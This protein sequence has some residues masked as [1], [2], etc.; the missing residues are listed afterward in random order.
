MIAISHRKGLRAARVIAMLL[1]AAGTGFVTAKL[2]GGGSVGLGASRVAPIRGRPVLAG[3][4]GWPDQSLSADQI[5]QRIKELSQASP[6]LW[7]DWEARMR[8]E[9]LIRGASVGAFAVWHQG[10]AAA[11]KNERVGNSNSRGNAPYEVFSDGPVLGMIYSVWCERDGRTAVEAA[12]SLGLKRPFASNILDSWARLE[13]AAAYEWTIA[14]ESARFLS[15]EEKADASKRSIAALAEKDFAGAKRRIEAGDDQMRAEMLPVL[16]DRLSD[17][18]VRREELIALASESPDREAVLSTMIRE[19]SR[20]SPKEAMARIATLDLPEETKASLENTCLAEVI[21]VFR[22][23]ES[24]EGWFER[25][26]QETEISSEVTRMLASWLSFRPETSL[27]WLNDFPAGEQRDRAFAALREEMRYPED[28]DSPEANP[29]ILNCVRSIKDD[30]LRRGLYQDHFKAL[31]R[32]D[33]AAAMEWRE[34]L[35]EADRPDVGSE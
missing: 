8:I 2:R 24:V 28:D 12:Y 17:D 10:I 1:I 23:P 21:V 16:M 33:E 27:K 26:P 18:P 29:R 5:R 11:L 4:N 25:H 32:R 22:F 19:W 3:K 20:S 15:G 34:T 35:P 13:P 31:L 7:R 30:G 14:K 6:E 9:R